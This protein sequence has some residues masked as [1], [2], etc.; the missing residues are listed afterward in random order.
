MADAILAATHCTHNPKRRDQPSDRPDDH[1]QP[2]DI[3]D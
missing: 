1:D 2:H 3:H